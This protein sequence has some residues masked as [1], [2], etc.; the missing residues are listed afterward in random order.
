MTKRVQS[1]SFMFN[2]KALFYALVVF[3]KK[4][5]YTKK[6]VN[7]YSHKKKRLE[8]MQINQRTLNRK[9]EGVNEKVV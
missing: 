1:A 7:K 2:T 8:S 3:L 6:G 5:E 9:R 4:W